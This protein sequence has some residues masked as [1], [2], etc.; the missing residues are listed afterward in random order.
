M[1]LSTGHLFR[2]LLLPP[3]FSIVFNLRV[4]ALAGN[5]QTK[6]NVFEIVDFASQKSYMSV[7]VTNTVYTEVAFNGTV[8][9]SSVVNVYDNY[10]VQDT[11]MRFHV[12]PTK[13]R[14][15]S[16][17]L[18]TNSLQYTIVNTYTT[19]RVFSLYLSSPSELGASG[20][21]S[22]LQFIT[23]TP[24]PTTMPSMEPTLCKLNMFFSP[25]TLDV[26]I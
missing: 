25:T 21:V 2:N 4:S 17:A 26:C 1:T 12:Y 16:N 6:L 22:Q 11:S 15:T 20:V 7:R 8:L 5:A 19:N 13:L 24:N 18:R 14:A 3:W 23:D 9:S 10:T